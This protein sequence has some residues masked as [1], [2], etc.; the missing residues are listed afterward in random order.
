MSNKEKFIEAYAIALRQNSRDFPGTYVCPSDG[1]EGLAR[2][3]AEG[4]IKRTSHTSDLAI[5]ICGKLGGRWSAEGVRA[6]LL[7]GSEFSL[8]A[9]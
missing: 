4:L 5:R 2:R 3:M 6:Y 1:W 8:G 7:Q 9:L